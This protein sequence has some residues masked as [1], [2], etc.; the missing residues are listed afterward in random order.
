MRVLIC[1]GGLVLAGMLTSGCATVTKTAEESTM[2][3]NQI[4]DLDARQVAEDWN[5]IWFAEHQTRLTRWHTR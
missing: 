2:N 3:I 4:A 1:L 5:S